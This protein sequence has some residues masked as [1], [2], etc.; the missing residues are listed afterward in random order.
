MPR[1]QWLQQDQCDK[2]RGIADVIDLLHAEAVFDAP[3]TGEIRVGALRL[4]SDDI[5]GLIIAS[6][7]R[8]ADE[9]TFIVSL[10]TSAQFRAKRR[11]STEIETF[12]I[13]QLDGASFDSRGNVELRDGTRLR[14]VEVIPSKLPYHVTELDWCILHHVIVFLGAESDCY[15]YPIRFEQPRDALDC[16]ALPALKRRIP[17]LKQIRFYIAEREPALKNLS[18]QKIADT[19]RMFGM[20]IPA[21]RTRSPTKI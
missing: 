15:R 18:E 1:Y 20:R 4:P 12:A 5:V 16:S 6:F 17:L 13:S 11:G 3:D 19:L 14:A 8:T 7:A 10:P 2:R 21:R 9:I